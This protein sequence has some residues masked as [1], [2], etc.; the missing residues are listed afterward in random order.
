MK[1]SQAAL[2]IV[3][4]ASIILASGYAF[5]NDSASKTDFTFS[6]NASRTEASIARYRGT[7]KILELPSIIEYVEVFE[8][9]SIMEYVEIKNYRIPIT[10]I[11]DEAFIRCDTLE[12]VIFPQSIRSIGK[13][14][15]AGCSSLQTVSLP[16][17]L[18]R[19]EEGTFSSCRSLTALII[20][21][22]VKVIERFAFID[23]IDLSTVQLPSSLTKIG[24]SAFR[25]CT[26]L[27]TQTM[28]ALAKYGYTRAGIDYM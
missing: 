28:T 18:T 25:G 21:D 9:P 4:F 5:A 3:G 20:P 6:V 24:I 8:L 26:K 16:L 7:A 12:T 11:A 1:H 23:C 17:G 22:S 27:D 10:A 13:R 19:I 14:A 2:L 15:F